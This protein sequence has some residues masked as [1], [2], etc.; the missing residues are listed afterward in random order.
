MTDEQWH[1]VL[2]LMTDSCP[3][4]RFTEVGISHNTAEA[5]RIK[6]MSALVYEQEEVKLSDTVYLTFARAQNEKTK[7]IMP[8]IIEKDAFQ[9]II[10]TDEYGNYKG[11]VM[12]DKSVEIKYDNMTYVSDLV[13]EWLGLNGVKEF[14]V[15]PKRNETEMAWERFTS[16]F[17]GISTKYL[18]EYLQWFCFL[19]RQ[20]VMGKSK[21]NI[22]DSLW[23]IINKYERYIS[24]R[25]FRAI[26]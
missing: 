12:P 20:E 18:N 9:V 19:R 24:N 4:S 22:V 2:S 25:N 14:T 13:R 6:I 15:L 16:C 8:E 3:L 7:A 1:S 21:E 10:A 5:V 11:D 23:Q 17:R 26:E